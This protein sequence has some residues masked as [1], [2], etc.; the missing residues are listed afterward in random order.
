MNRIGFVAI[1]SLVST[2]FFAPPPQG[3]DL[4]RRVAAAADGIVKMTYAAREGVCG[5]GR[6]F[7]AEGPIGAR[8]FDVWFTDGNSFSTMSGDIGA[9]CLNGPARVVLVVRDHRVV[10]VQPFV[11]PS[12]AASS[13]SG[14]DLGTVAVAEVARYMLDLATRGR[15]E[16]ARNAMLAASIADSVRIAQ[17]LAGIARNKTLASAVRETALK[18]VGRAAVRE[19]D[20]EAT[21]VARTIL[22][23]RDDQLDVRERAVRVVGEESDGPAYLRSAYARVTES[24]LRERIVRVVGESGTRADLDWIRNVALDGAERTAIR[25]R[26]VRTLGEA[27]DA[28][29]LRELYDRLDDATLRER[30]VRVMAEVGDNDSRRWLRDLVER[31]SE[32]ST[33]R[34]RAIR[35]LAELGDIAYLQSS[36]RSVDDEGL[37]E[38]ILRSVA[39][40]GGSDTKKWLGDIAR[41]TKEQTSLRE[42]AV[43]SLAESGVAT[44]ELVTLYDGIAD[45]TVRERLV[46]VLAER[47]DRAARDKL[48]AIAENDADEDLRRRAVRKLAESR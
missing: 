40:G 45:R 23:D 14:T 26:A 2:A 28:K 29:A 47:G 34:E 10:D 35:S 6:S 3:G 4:A 17:P 30:I 41:D 7:V 24:T 33:V 38:R 39:E 25:E 11:G 37:R 8:G 21:R 48:R 15:E 19:G 42:R 22:D 16:T 9:K 36:Y 12:S 1:A 31:K 44:S 13:R 27:S 20:R 5:D 18:W 32:S 43:R 46:N